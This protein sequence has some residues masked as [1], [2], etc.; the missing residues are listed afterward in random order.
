M[1]E[2][3]ADVVIIGA[4]VGGMTAA[5]LLAKNGLKVL[6]FEQMTEVGGACSSF[7]RDGYSFDI[8]AV[9]VLFKELY[10]RLFEML[11]RPLEEY[12]PMQLIDPCYD[13]YFDFGGKVTVYNSIDK[14]CENIENNV[15]SE[16]A[17]AYRR[18]CKLMGKQWKGVQAFTDK[19]FPKIEK[20]ATPGFLAGRMM[21]PKHLM[22]L[23]YTLFIAS[24]SQ[25]RI[26]DRF[27]RHPMTRAVTGFENL[28]AGLPSDKI[29]GLF[30]ALS[31][32]CHE[33]YYY[34]E[35]GMVSI[36]RALAKVARENG[37]EIR[38]ETDIERIIV[39]NG[40]AV[41]VKLRNGEEVRSKIVLSNASAVP[42]Y[43]GLVGP[44]YLPKSM[45][46]GIQSWKLSIPA[47]NLYFGLKSKP[48][49]NAWGTVMLPPLE[50]MD[51]YWDTYY[52]NGIVGR[53][54]D[55]P[56]GLICPGL[57]D[58]TL[59]PAGKTGAQVITCGPYRL[60]HGTWDDVKERFLEETAVSIDRRCYPEFS[61]MVE[62]QDMSS[63]LDFERRVRLPEGSIYGLEMSVPNLG[64][65]RA[66]W[67]SPAVENLYLCGASTNPGGGVPL[68][69]ASGLIASSL[70]IQNWRKRE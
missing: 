35:G 63:P 70:I 60:N 8:G 67:K 40:K 15:S 19:P 3:S 65:F 16:E 9:F 11:E 52:P 64:P 50:K 61:S 48:K 57:R 47:P 68:V 17:H 27:F 55:L 32:L 69:M 21:T 41:G 12:I 39:E 29:N 24:G 38:L 37:A 5:A 56:M 25:R 2:N 28:Y 51:D 14:T 34:P 43:L 53:A 66:S 30:M 10:E 45:I 49:L 1:K 44:D 58:D 4:G 31:Y 7:E 33:G 23:P 22:A 13:V 54:D 62:L 26:I 59:A 42:T 6:Q 36:A 18:F 20:I 46:K